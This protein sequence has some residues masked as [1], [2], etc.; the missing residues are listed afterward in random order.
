MQTVQITLGEVIEAFY[1]DLYETYGDEELAL[2]A[3]QA[4]ASELLM[5]ARAQPPAADT[6]PVELARAA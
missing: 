5:H 2:A 4:I 1:D 3:A 6:A